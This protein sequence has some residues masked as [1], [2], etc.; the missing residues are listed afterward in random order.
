[1]L[2]FEGAIADLAGGNKPN[3]TLIKAGPASQ[4]RPALA[5]DGM[6]GC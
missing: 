1:M 5:G 3:V 2:A 4:S 6:G